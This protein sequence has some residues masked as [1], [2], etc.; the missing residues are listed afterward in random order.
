M[1]LWSWG[2]VAAV[3]G[4]VMLVVSTLWFRQRWYE[5]FLLSHIVMLL[6]GCWY[7]SALRF[8][9]TGQ[10]FNTWI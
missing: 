10:G 3:L 5:L 1:P 4:S 6:V 2:S 9:P 7:H 8:L